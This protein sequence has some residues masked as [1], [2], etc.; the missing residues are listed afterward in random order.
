MCRYKGKQDIENM[1]HKKFYYIKVLSLLT[2]VDCPPQNLAKKP[3][4]ANVY[5]DPSVLINCGNE[6]NPMKSSQTEY[7]STDLHT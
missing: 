2:L 3:Q 1:K 7:G 4:F 6:T 5:S